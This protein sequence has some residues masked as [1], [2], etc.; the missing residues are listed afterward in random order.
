MVYAR[1]QC[2][3]ILVCLATNYGVETLFIFITILS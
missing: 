1:Q 2:P 3:N